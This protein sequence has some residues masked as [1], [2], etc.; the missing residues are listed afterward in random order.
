[1]THP[2]GGT[3]FLVPFKNPSLR[4]PRILLQRKTRYFASIFFHRSNFTKF[5]KQEITISKNSIQT[6]NRG[7]RRGEIIIKET[8]Q[9]EIYV[10]E[11]LSLNKTER[12]RVLISIARRQRRG[13]GGRKRRRG[14]YPASDKERARFSIRDHGTVNRAR[15][16][17]NRDEFVVINEARALSPRV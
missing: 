4:S 15:S 3:K 6:R 12:A 9:L 2:A 5:I 7:G 1:M 16:V 8:R 14:G 10:R 11:Y 13:A 17:I